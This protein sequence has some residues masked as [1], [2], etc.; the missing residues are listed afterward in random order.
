MQEILG[1][2]LNYNGGLDAIFKIVFKLL[3]RFGFQKFNSGMT[4]HISIK[5]NKELHLLFMQNIPSDV[6]CSNAYY[7]F[8]NLAMNEKEWKELK[9][10]SDSL[11]LTFFA[12]IGDD[13]GLKL[14]E[15]IGCESIKNKE[16][17]KKSHVL[18]MEI[19]HFPRNKKFSN[20]KSLCTIPLRCRYCTAD[21]ILD[22]N[23]EARSWPCILGPA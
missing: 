11:G 5:N 2:A 7:S 6:Y 13:M 18:S 21:I 16:T 19:T 15:T 1:A 22:I 8:P 20:F 9:L 23:L 14:L 12:T 17:N 10:Y 3:K 4:R